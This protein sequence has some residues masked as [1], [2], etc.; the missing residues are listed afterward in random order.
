MPASRQVLT[1]HPEYQVPIDLFVGAPATPA[2]L[3]ALLGPFSQVREIVAQGIEEMVVGGKDPIDA[4]N[5][6][7]DRAT[8]E[9][10]EYNRR[11]GE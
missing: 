11:V 10:E 7:A 8:Q 9:L 4:L 5:D 6:A 3:G 1:E 2:K